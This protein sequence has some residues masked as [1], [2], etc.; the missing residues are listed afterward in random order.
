MAKVIPIGR[1]HTSQERFVEAVGLVLNAR[2]FKG[3][4][5]DA[6][7][8]EA[9]LQKGLIRMLFGSFLNLIKVYAHSELH[10]PTAE[11]LLDGREEELKH[12]PPERQFAWF[13]RHLLAALRRRPQTVQILIWELTERDERSELLSL[14]RVRRT[15]EFF[16]R[17][18]EDTPDDV[19]LSA[20]VALLAGA[21]QFLVI[22]ARLHSHYGGID[23]DDEAGWAR[24]DGAIDLLLQGAL[25]RRG[26]TPEP[27]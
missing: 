16:E 27:A 7:A 25:E 11:E 15:L 6:V 5:P 26:G 10:W 1:T 22:R 2:G 24:I 21:V 14:V 8:R 18:R 9:G 13:F 23:L 17:L 4:T 12:L 20:I 3:L 19:D